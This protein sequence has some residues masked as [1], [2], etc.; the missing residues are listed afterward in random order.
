MDDKRAQAMF[1]ISDDPRARAKRIAELLSQK[2]RSGEDFEELAYLLAMHLGLVDVWELRRELKDYELSPEEAAAEREQS[3]CMMDLWLEQ[4]P[5]D[6][7]RQW[8]DGETDRRMWELWER[9]RH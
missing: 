5:E 7:D 2:S 3:R 1:R 9:S 4:Y 8:W 6:R